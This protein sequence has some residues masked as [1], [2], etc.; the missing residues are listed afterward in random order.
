MNKQAKYVS[1]EP[2]GFSDKSGK[3]NLEPVY[4][5][6]DKPVEGGGSV[7]LNSAS[8]KDAGAGRGKQG[9]PTAGQLK[10][11]E[12]EDIQDAVQKARAEKKG[13]TVEQMRQNMSDEFDKRVKA[14][15]LYK[16]GGTVSASKRAD[17]A[18]IRGKTRGRIY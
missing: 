11:Q 9:G 17:G 8:E 14:G 10:A 12:V 1:K 2:V 4:A 3:G 7:Y 6:K 15:D 18:A 13:V 5:Y 16:K